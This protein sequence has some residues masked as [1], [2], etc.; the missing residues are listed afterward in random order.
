MSRRVSLA[1]VATAADVN[2]TWVWKARDL[3]L[4]NPLALDG[5]DVIV[6]QVLAFVDQLAW[7]GQRRSRSVSRDMELWQTLAVTAAREAAGDPRTTSETALWVMPDGVRLATTPGERSSCELDHLAGKVAF[8]LPIGQWVDD[9]PENFRVG[10][11]P[12]L[13]ALSGG[14][15]A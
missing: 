7:P 6:V 9:L 15:V 12:A 1:A 11:R 5:E 10:I 13:K 3:G 4:I 2:N 14:S 8:R